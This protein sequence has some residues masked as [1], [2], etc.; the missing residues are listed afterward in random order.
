MSTLKVNN[1][2]AFTSGTAVSFGLVSFPNGISG[3]L[4]AAT[5]N[6]QSG[7]YY[8]DAA[9]L[10]GTINATQLNSQSAGFYTNATNITGTFNAVSA[11]GN[12]SFD[13]GSFVFNEAGADKDFRIEGDTNS[14]LLFADASVDRIGIGLSSPATRLDVSGNFSQNIVA[15]AALDID[16]SQGN[17]FTKTINGAS[18]FTF[19]NVPATRSYS[20][21]LELTHTSGAVTWPAEVKWNADTA[22]TL[23]AGKTH[24]F[25]FVTDDGGT[26]WRG[27]ALVDYVN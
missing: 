26:R 15:V 27:A 8:R 12:V 4:D 17:Y 18:T 6:S 16:C 20:F 13:G 24:I 10:T 9:N 22:P 21:T 11:S 19:S 5:L 14:G 3:A 23:T 1:I 2:Q 7:S 25:I